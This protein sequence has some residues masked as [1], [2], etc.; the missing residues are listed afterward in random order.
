MYTSSLLFPG[1]LMPLKPGF[2]LV[3]LQVVPPLSDCAR[4]GAALSRDRYRALERCVPP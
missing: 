1:Q 4:R 3:T 2:T